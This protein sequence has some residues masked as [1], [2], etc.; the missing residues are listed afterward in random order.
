AVRSQLPAVV[1]AAAEARPTSDVAAGVVAVGG[2]AA[3]A[4]AGIGVAAF[5]RGRRRG[6]RPSRF[7]A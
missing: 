3:A 6:W 7:R 2:V 1:P 4:A 5:R